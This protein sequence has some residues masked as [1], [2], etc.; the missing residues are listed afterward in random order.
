MLAFSAMVNFQPAGSPAPTGYLV[1]SGQAYGPR[2]DGLTYG[3]SADNTANVRERP[4]TSADRRFDT[5]AMMQ[6]GGVSRAWEI[7]VPNGTYRVHTV[8]GDSQFPTGVVRLMAENQTAAHGTTTPVRRWVEGWG[9]VTVTDGRLTLW[10]GSGSEN[11]KIDF[12]EITDNLASPIAPVKLPQVT[13]DVTIGMNLDGMADYATISP[14]TDLATLFRK[15]APVETP[16]EPDD[17]IPRTADNYPLADAAAITFATGY[18]SGEYQVSYRGA[19]DVAFARY[20]N[21]DGEN[22]KLDDLSFTPV[23]QPDGRKTGTLTLEIPA[24]PEAWYFAMIVTNVSETDPLRD[25]HI[26]SPDAN[27]AVSNVFRPVFLEKLAPFDGPL[28]VMDWMM[29]NYSPVKKWDD[30][31]RTSRFSYVTPNGMPYERWIELANVLHKDLWV[32]VPHEA[33]DTYIQSLAALLRDT[34][35]PSLK[36]FVEYSNEAWN[37]GSLQ[38]QYL[39]ARGAANPNT[40]GG[41]FERAAQEMGRQTAKIATHFKSVFGAPRYAVQVRPVI[42]AFIANPSWAHNA[43]EYVKQK[44]GDPRDYIAGVAVA[45]YVGNEGDMGDLNDADLTV[46]ELFAWMHYR[47][48]TTIS[49]WLRAHKA[50][51]DRYEVALE[52]YEG[53]QHLQSV[54]FEGNEPVKR[55]AQDDPRMADVYRHLLRTWVSLGGDV[56][57]NFTLATKPSK[58]GYWGLLEAI[59]RPDSLKYQTVRDLATTSWQFRS[60]PEVIVPGTPPAPPKPSPKPAPQAKKPVPRTATAPLPT[61]QP[62]KPV[63]APKRLSRLFDDD[64]H[65]RRG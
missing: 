4:P 65:P 59:D 49:D 7:A 24:K 32:N 43:L 36:V 21:V 18:P 58:Y 12:V 28:R 56:F 40:W 45:P 39:Y 26:I 62:K 6:P 14:F 60:T 51:T 52:A 55:A 27:P 64:I 63:F 54:L 33:N 25:L 35:D 29:T 20:H 50:I 11:L 53:G 3:W 2:G 61:P 47:I 5:L 30:R 8:S 44:I 38:G 1:D 46:D 17:T 16:W 42:G 48:D 31:T 19:G 9:T 10:P 15:W 37:A 41:P 22:L 34:L 57:A 23:A 13:H